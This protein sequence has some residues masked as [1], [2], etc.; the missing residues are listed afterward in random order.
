MGKVINEFRP[1]YVSPPGETLLEVLESLGMTQAEL[2]R[3]TGR[4]KKTINEIIQGRATITPETALQLELTLDIPASFWN[5]REQQYQE[6]LARIQEEEELESQVA[7]LDELPVSE[8]CRYGWVPRCDNP[9]SQLRE[10]LRFFGVVSVAQW[11]EVWNLPSFNFRQSTA[12]SINWGAVA[13]WLRKGELEAQAIDCQPYDNKLFRQTLEEIRSLTTLPL[14]EAWPAV[15]EKCP[16]A[17]VAV[18]LVPSLPNTG[19]CGATK[20]LS[21]KKALL[22]LSL[23]YKSNDQFWFTLFHEAGHI[24]LHGKSKTFLETENGTD[25]GNQRNNEE[26]EA[27]KFAADFLIPPAKL[28][29]FMATN[30]RMSKNAVISFANELGIAP[31]IVVGRLQHDHKLPRTHLNGLRRRIDFDESGNVVTVQKT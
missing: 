31:D 17:G 2:A 7:W 27:N 9:V 16:A 30:Q 23:R 15:I 3:R 24:L 4:P 5:N 1:D 11:H 14:E 26:E 6:A 10:L 12:R 20:W 18:V 21:P 8:I 28:K 25:K 13:A 29:H 22:Q 19:I